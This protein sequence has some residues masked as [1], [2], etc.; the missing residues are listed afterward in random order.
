MTEPT[1][2]TPAED[3]PEDI[4]RTFARCHWCS[5]FAAGARLITAIEQG[6][7]PGGNLFA[8]KPCRERYGLVPLTDRP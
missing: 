2:T 1:Q 6:S 8:C 4:P 7:G 5:T 3:I